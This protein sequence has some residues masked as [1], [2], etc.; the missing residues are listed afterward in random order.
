MLRI[1]R[2]TAPFGLAASVVKLLRSF[3]IARHFQDTTNP[4]FPSLLLCPYQ[5]SSSLNGVNLETLIATLAIAFPNITKPTKTMR[6][7]K[8]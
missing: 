1:I 8:Q 4:I 7:K 6:I 3:F 2:N 5:L